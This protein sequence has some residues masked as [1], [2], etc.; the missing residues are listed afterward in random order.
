M[1]GTSAILRRFVGRR[2]PCIASR[3][4]SISDNLIVS[5]AAAAA[6]YSLTDDGA[7]PLFVSAVAPGNAAAFNPVFMNYSRNF[8][9]VPSSDSSKVVSIESEEQFNDA[10][11]KIKEESLPAIFYF[12][13]VWCPPCRLLS[14]IIEQL[15]EKYPHVT[16]YKVDIDKKG[17]ENAVSQQNI[18]SVPTLHFFQNGKKADEV[19][20]ANVERLKD[21]MEALYE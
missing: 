8:S 3:S 6:S 13:A 7:R 12:T 9:S 1:R 4:S 5:S 10:V 14:P 18:H 19:V 2:A 15:S 17:L 11:R 20:G 16:T 21:I